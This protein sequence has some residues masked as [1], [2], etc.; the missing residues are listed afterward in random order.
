M[1]KLEIH[2]FLIL[3]DNYAVLLHDAEAGVTGSIDAGDAEAI[4]AEADKL[5]WKITHIMT[6]HHHGDHTQGNKALK[7]ET[8][9]Q[10]VGPRAEAGKV[11]GIDVELAE[12]D[13]FEFG[14]FKFQIFETG[15][16]TAGHISYFEPNEKVAFVG[17]T[18]FALGCGRLFEGDARQMWQSLSKLKALPPETVVYCGHEYTEANANFALTIEPENEALQARV[19]E[20]K[21]LRAAGKPTLPTTIGA[22]LETSPFMRPDSAAIRKRFGMEGAADWEVFGE[23]RRRKDEA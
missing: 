14:D 23:V 5:G 22:E 4:K 11:P 21:A 8:G 7:A 9:C 17:D 15:G 19:K 10:I 12:G 16:H 13:T 20:I 2:Q 18:M 3:D 1:A 6:T